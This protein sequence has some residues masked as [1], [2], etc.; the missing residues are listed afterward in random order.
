MCCTYCPSCLSFIWIPSFP[1]LSIP[2][3]CWMS[4]DLFLLELALYHLWYPQ[5]SVYEPKGDLKS[6]SLLPSIPN[7]FLDPSPTIPPEAS[8]SMVINW[9]K[10][11]IL[12][13]HFGSNSIFCQH[14]LNKMED[15]LSP[16]HKEVLPNSNSQLNM[17]DL[18]WIDEKVLAEHFRCHV[19]RTTA[20]SSSKLICP[21]SLFTKTKISNFEVS[22][23]INHDILRFDVPVDNMLV[24]KILYPKQDLNKAIS[25]LILSHSL[26]FSQVI[27]KLSTRTI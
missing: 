1:L 13:P 21:Q 17:N 26:H 6:T 22:V 23:H 19:L 27:E 12:C 4:T 24:V 15:F 10:K 16:V 2:S 9:H 5:A 7:V 18:I 14:L 11:G 3:L 8:W 25:S 20:I